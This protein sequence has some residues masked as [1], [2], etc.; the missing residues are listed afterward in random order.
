MKKNLF[1][2][3]IRKIHRY[4]GVI[5]GIQFIAWTIGGLYFS[6]TKID[7]IR[8]ENI[9][10]EKKSIAF[11]ENTPIFKKLNQLYGDF[12]I[13]EAKIVRILENNYYQILFKKPE[14]K[15]ILLDYESFEL[16]KPISKEEAEIIAAQSIK[17][18]GKI[19]STIYLSETSKHHEYRNKPLPAYAVK[20]KDPSPITVYISSELGTV[21][22]FRNNSWKIFDFL[23]MLHTMDYEGR[24]NFNNLL[25]RVFSIFGLIT[26][27]SGFMLYFL[28]YRR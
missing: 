6:W 1:Q 8:G 5:L 12:L 10:A 23:W 14:G 11:N 15:I 21:Q 3:N 4:L 13:E 17:Q 18:P 20:F 25:L 2:R 7:H 26:I 22:T 16:R 24:D 27:L 28:T 19:S 9:E